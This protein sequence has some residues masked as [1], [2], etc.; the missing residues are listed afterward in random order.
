MFGFKTKFISSLIR[1]KSRCK[2]GGDQGQKGALVL[3]GVKLGSRQDE[4]SAE[5]HWPIFLL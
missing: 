1:T 2:R 3:L 4:C 5:Q